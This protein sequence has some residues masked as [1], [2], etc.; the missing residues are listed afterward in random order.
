M[1]ALWGVVYPIVMGGGMATSERAVQMA[2][3]VS[4]RSFATI[5]DLDAAS[6][7]PA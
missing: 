7:L 2:T 5:Q 4:R 6:I 1:A 3:E